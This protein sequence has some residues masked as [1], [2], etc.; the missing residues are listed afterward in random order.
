[1]APLIGVDF[2]SRPTARKPVVVRRA[3]QAGAA[4]IVVGRLTIP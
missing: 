2:S 4:P 1:M 3:A